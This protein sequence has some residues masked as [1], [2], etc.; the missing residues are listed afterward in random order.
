MICTNVSKNLNNEQT[1]TYQHKHMHINHI[2]TLLLNK[3]Y[4]CQYHHILFLINKQKNE[5]V[6]YLNGPL[7]YELYHLHTKTTKRF[8]QLL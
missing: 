7:N 6:Q 2:I 5:I 4:Y 1:N 3:T 8:Q